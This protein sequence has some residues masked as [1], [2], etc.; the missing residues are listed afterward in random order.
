MNLEDLVKEFAD[1]VVAQSQAMAKADPNLGNKFAR[2]YMA[3][4]EQL[5][6]RGDEARQALAVLLRDSRADV[7]VMAA[8]YLLRYKHDQ[9]KSVLEADAKGVGL[10]AFGAAQAL[11]RWKE[12]AWALDPE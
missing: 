7:R 6:S 8:A 4:F 9:A 1:C 10:V 2:H 12:G 11:Q 5:R 3:A